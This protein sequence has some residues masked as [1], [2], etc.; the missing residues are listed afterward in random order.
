MIYRRLALCIFSLTLYIACNSGR[1]LLNS[2]AANSDKKYITLRNQKID[3]LNSTA[4]KL[5]GHPYKLGS[6]GPRSFDCSGFISTVFQSIKL[7]LPRVAANQAHLGNL[8][9]LS[10]VQTGDLLFFG[11]RK[12][13]DHVAFV[14]QKSSGKT[15]IIHATSS[16]GVILEILEESDYWLKRYK[17]SRRVI[18]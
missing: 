15:F 6:A 1:H 10:K 17:T 11:D 13:I 2:D 16:S 5:L 3:K 18:I 4:K 9:K 14:S 12:G 7:S 8:L